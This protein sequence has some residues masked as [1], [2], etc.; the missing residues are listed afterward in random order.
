MRRTI[1]ASV[2]AVTVG[3]QPAAA[4]PP[5]TGPAT[6]GGWEIRYNA[7]L[8]LARRGSDA[9]GAPLTRDLLLELLDEDRQRSNFRVTLNSGKTLPDEVGARTAVVG[10]L[11]ALVELHRRR[12]DISLADFLPPI[13]ELAESST[14]PVVRTEAKQALLALE[15]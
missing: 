14:N 1:W 5:P 8:A 12:P 6:P 3:C 13:R 11:K 9:A 15:K 7:A 10:T 4:P 2:F